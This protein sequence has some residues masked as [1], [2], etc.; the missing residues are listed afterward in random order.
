MAY[1]AL[2]RIEVMRKKQKVVVK[3][4][5]EFEFTEGEVEDLK[6]AGAIE[7]V[8]STKTSGSTTQSKPKPSGGSGKPAPKKDEGDDLG[9]GDQK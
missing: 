2:N 4:G 8:K 7:E 9:L 1:Q 6:A 5:D 3:P